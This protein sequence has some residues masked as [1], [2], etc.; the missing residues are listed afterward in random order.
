MPLPVRWYAPC[1]VMEK[2]TGRAPTLI[3][4]VPIIPLAYVTILLTP[5]SYDPITLCP[6]MPVPTP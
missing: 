1:S 5:C 4:Y 2:G 6:I 3:G